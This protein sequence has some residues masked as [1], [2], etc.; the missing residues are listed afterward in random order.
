[1]LTGAGT[2]R[3]PFR[4]SA[5][6]RTIREPLPLQ[7]TRDSRDPRR[8]ATIRRDPRTCP[9]HVPAATQ[10]VGRRSRD[11]FASSRRRR[12]SSGSSQIRSSPHARWKS[13]SAG[14]CG[15]RREPRAAPPV[16]C[17]SRPIPGRALGLPSR[18]DAHNSGKLDRRS[19]ALLTVGHQSG[20]RE[21]EPSDNREAGI[22]EQ[23]RDRPD[24]V[25]VEVA[26]GLRELLPRHEIRG[27][28]CP[29]RRDEVRGRQPCRRRSSTQRAC[30]ARARVSIS[31][32]SNST[33]L[34]LSPTPNTA[35]Q[36]MD[37]S[38]RTM[39]AAWSRFEAR[40]DSSSKS[41]LRRAGSPAVANRQLC[42]V[43]RSPRGWPWQAPRSRPG[44]DADRDLQRPRT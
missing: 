20:L 29:R 14:S 24:A 6:L 25:S 16:A 8:R 22:V 42:G 31:S 30:S 15:P 27:E 28:L 10:Q 32:G 34:P 11:P 38:L 43:L 21:P 7:P 23:A 12:R 44:G 36:P 5:C 37:A 3:E 2:V 18:L 19:C 35:W 40:R 4:R 41:Q 17:V 9:G 26:H 33:V 1:M 39:S 13:H